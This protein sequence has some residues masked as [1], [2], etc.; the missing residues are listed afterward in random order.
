[1]LVL[2]DPGL[3]GG[4]ALPFLG[5]PVGFGKRHPGLH[6]RAGLDAEEDGEVG[7]VRAHAGF[8]PCCAPKDAPDGSIPTVPQHKSTPPGTKATRSGSGM[9]GGADPAPGAGVLPQHKPVR[10]GR[11]M[12]DLLAVEEPGRAQGPSPTAQTLR[13]RGA[14]RSAG[15]PSSPLVYLPKG[16][17]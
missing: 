5:A 9:D 12:I 11:E 8:L 7:V 16:R 17:G 3:P 15:H 1:R 10:R 6:A 14:R 13:T 4:D 2:F